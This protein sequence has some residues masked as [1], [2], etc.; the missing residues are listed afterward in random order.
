MYRIRTAILLGLILGL[1]LPALGQAEVWRC[2]QPDG[3]DLFT[4]SLK[5]P[6]TCKKYTSGTE[7]GYV[8]GAME[9]TPPAPAM[10]PPVNVQPDQTE[11]QRQAPEPSPP[12]G[13][14]QEY[15]PYHYDDYPGVY[16]LF[17]GPRSFSFHRH[18]HFHSAP[19]SGFH[20]G[21]GHGGGGHR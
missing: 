8:Y 3:T 21:G 10:A 20:H 17:I 18:S 16:G 19:R 11:P 5:D 15:Y 12:P 13:Y 14:E 1:L 6:A 9:A 4:N 2:P 7:L